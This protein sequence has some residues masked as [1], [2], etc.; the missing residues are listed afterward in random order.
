MP[1][2]FPIQ[3]SEQTLTAARP[4]RFLTV[5][6]FD[7][8]KAQLQ[9]LQSGYIL[10]KEQ[11][12]AITLS[13]NGQTKKRIFLVLKINDDAGQNQDNSYAYTKSNYKYPHKAFVLPGYDVFE[14]SVA[15]GEGAAHLHDTVGLGE[16]ALVQFVH[17]LVKF[18]KALSHLHI[19][20]G[21]GAKLMVDINK[22][23]GLFGGFIR[24]FFDSI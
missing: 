8:P 13:G 7:Y 9:D 1:L 2:G 15:G 18:V 24:D 17:S 10:F 14:V 11:K 5:F 22:G 23:I 19:G 21:S 16:G 6:P 12:N 3:Q 4:S 20:I